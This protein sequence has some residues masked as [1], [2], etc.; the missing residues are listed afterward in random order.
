ME[1]QVTKDCKCLNI[2]FVVCV[3]QSGAVALE[4]K[5]SQYKLQLKRMVKAGALPQGNISTPD[6]ITM[7]MT[8]THT[9]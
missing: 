3:I 7:G 6:D 4:W 9:H 2:A 1:L 5:A 8:L